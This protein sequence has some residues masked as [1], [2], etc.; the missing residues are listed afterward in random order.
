[1]SVLTFPVI[2][3]WIIIFG[4]GFGV[5]NLKNAKWLKSTEL[6]YRGD[7]DAQGFEILSQ[8]RGYFPNAKSILMDKI[9]FD[10]HFENDKGTPSRNSTKLNLTVGEIEMYELI[11]ENN[12]RLEQEKISLKYVNDTIKNQG[13][14]MKFN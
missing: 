6:Y 14:G 3:E 8:F 1:M 2:S 10:Q 5:E 11:K 7:L 12:W 4:C 13:M 9:T